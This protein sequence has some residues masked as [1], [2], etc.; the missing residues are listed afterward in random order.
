[1]A[2]VIWD[3]AA[4]AAMRALKEATD[5]SDMEMQTL[6]TAIG[7]W[8]ANNPD[9]TAIFQFPPLKVKDHFVRA[10]TKNGH[11]VNIAYGD[12]V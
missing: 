10:F 3:D 8:A 4:N 9:G 11:V 2:R 7:A 12:K 1:M 5:A 6:L